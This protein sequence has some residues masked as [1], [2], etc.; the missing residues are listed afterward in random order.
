MTRRSD[1]Y[2]Q[3]IRGAI[4]RIRDYTQGLDEDQFRASPLVQDAVVQNLEIIGEAAGRISEEVRAG[5]PAV[6]WRKLWAFR[7][8]VAHHCWTVDLDVV[9]DVI[10]N[11]LDEITAALGEA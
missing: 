9:W 7:N 2:V 1:L 10:V 8:I 6:P 5:H 11:K 4:A 3:D